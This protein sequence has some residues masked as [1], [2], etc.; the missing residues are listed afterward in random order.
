MTRPDHRRCRDGG[1]GARTLAEA[2]E[3][4][5]NR[6]RLLFSP[7]GAENNAMRL[8]GCGIMTGALLWLA[9]PAFG[10]S[11]ADHEACVKASGDAAI[12]GCTRIIDDRGETARSRAVAHFNRGYEWR[13]KGEHDRA[14]ADY[15]E[16]IR[17]DPAYVFAFNNRAGAYL[18][19]G[20]DD[21]AIA[22][23]GEAIRIEPRF[24]AAL[25]ARANAYAA[26]REFD[27]AIADYD[28]LIRLNPRD[29]P[30][31]N[32]RGFMY[33]RNGD[34]DRALVNFNE[35]I[36]LN[37][38]Y[39][40]AFNNRGLVHHA[41]G[42]AAR[43]IVDF[44]EA[45]RRDP[46]MPGHYL[47][48]GL[49]YLLLGSLPRALADFNR[50]SELDPKHPYVIL[51]QDIAA[52]RSNQPSRLAQAMMQIDMTR[53]PAPVVRLYLGQITPEAVLAAAD[54]PD[55]DIRKAQT[56]EAHFFAGELALLAGSKD[57]AAR[58]FRLA[59]A[60]CGQNTHPWVHANAE[61]KA[62]GARP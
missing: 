32:N 50:S 19:K 45:I 15:S 38:G 4:D 39:V 36:R 61:L 27:R 28:Q 21:R 49:A 7:A 56:C 22:D 47:N 10:A 51:W 58:R 14:I 3:Q 57:E 24:A 43:A 33:Y 35:A 60:A 48:R 52:R 2:Q 23:Y 59:A 11:P 54:H 8:V 13:A 25:T 6:D 31:F 18:D 16:A 5:K 53:W 1:E 37:P 30:A 41:K 40:L 44:D 29:A 55:A 42:D 12:A 46:S 20:D 26:R 9:A 17:L 62:L 34:L